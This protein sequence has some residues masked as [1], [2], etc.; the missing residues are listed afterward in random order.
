MI[1]NMSRSYNE[2]HKISRTEK[3]PSPYIDNEGKKK[4][5]RKMIPYGSEG[6]CGFGGEFYIRKWGEIL[7]DVVKKRKARKLA[8]KQILEYLNEDN[9]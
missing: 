1:L 3:C 2:H 8:K 4:R 9:R 6:Y 5:H 7:M